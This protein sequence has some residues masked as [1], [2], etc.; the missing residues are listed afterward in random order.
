VFMGYTKQPD[1]SIVPLARQ[2]V[3]TGMGVER[4]LM[5]LNGFTS[6]YEVDTVAPV[7]QALRE[8]TDR[9]Q[10]LRVLVD[11]VRAS[12]QIIIDGIEPS[13]KDRGYV[14]RRLI[15]RC[16]LFAKQLGLPRDWYVRVVPPGVVDTIAHELE[17]FDKTLAHGLKVLTKLPAIDGKTAF[18]L[19]QTYGFPF[20][21]T[22]E[23]AGPKVDHASFR[24]ALDERRR[25]SR[26]TTTPGGLAD[27]SEASTRYHTLTHLLQAAL[28]EVLG[29]HVIQRGSNITPE[30]LRFDF[31]HDDKPTPE[32]LARVE[33][34]VNTW[35]AR[36]LVV[37]RTSMS[38]PDARA[39][40]AIGA[41]GEKYGDV[42][43]VYTVLD[44]ITRDV[45]SREFCGGPHVRSTHELRGRFRIVRE[46][47]ISAGI[48]RIKALLEVAAHE[49]LALR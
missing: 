29:P 38:E 47:S 40:G 27:H 31:A 8:L 17:R 24:E 37:E 14:L 15:R 41:F 12:T 49:E 4:T 34:R 3:D 42:V 36:D 10:P 43:S 6:V 9:E 21:L 20:E 11:H 5:A 26:T 35:L 25:R 33:E 45:V 1:G 7:Y 19:F 23:L 46:Q 48:R 30:R 39:L 28:R 13:N 18:D 22:L 16:G 32:Q 2:N 44:P